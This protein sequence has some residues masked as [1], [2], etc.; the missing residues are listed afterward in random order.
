[1]RC[2]KNIA[3]Q[4]RVSI[5]GCCLESPWV[6]NENG[7]NASSIVVRIWAT[8]RKKTRTY[9]LEYVQASSGS[10]R[11][12]LEAFCA[13]KQVP[14]A[15]PSFRGNP[16][17]VSFRGTLTFAKSRRSLNLFPSCRRK[18]KQYTNMWENTWK[19]VKVIGRSTITSK[20]LGG[21]GRNWKKLDPKSR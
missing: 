18:Q 3:K 2:P 11:R 1:M 21:S 15:S 10:K 4:P 6:R 14:A 16:R 5:L 20:S 7:H 13:E 8:V 12:S 17:L 9:T 19:R